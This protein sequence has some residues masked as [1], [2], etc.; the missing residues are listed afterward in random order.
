MEIPDIVPSPIGEM[1][2]SI[3]RMILKLIFLSAMI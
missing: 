3:V 2:L 1:G